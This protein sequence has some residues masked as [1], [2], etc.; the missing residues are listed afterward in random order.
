MNATVLK[1]KN[2]ENVSKQVMK[3]LNSKDIIEELEMSDRVN[4]ELFIKVLG[5]SKMATLL[6]SLARQ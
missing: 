4:A 1:A 5:N 2:Q 3:E 6:N